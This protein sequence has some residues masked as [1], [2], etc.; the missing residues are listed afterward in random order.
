[1]GNELNVFNK[2][3]YSTWKYPSNWPGNIKHFFRCFKYAYQRATKGFCDWDAWDLD[4]YYS[5]LFVNS[6]RYFADH[7]HG[8]PGNDEFPQPEDWDKYLRTMADLF[9]QSIEGCQTPKNP[10]EKE[11]EDMIS[12]DNWINH[13]NEQ[14]PEQKE[15][16]KKYL[17]GE[18]T[19]D[20]Y[21]TECRNKA[22][23]MMKHV[24]G[25]LWD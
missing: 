19:L 22:F 11:F 4:V 8:W 12:Q 15:I 18:I 7:T 21:R 13:I 23:D 6:L 16:S 2:G 25:H 20:N 14:T 1:M 17:D 24:F 5:F 3:N 9:E 10:Y